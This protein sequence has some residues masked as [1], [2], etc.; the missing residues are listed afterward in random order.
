MVLRLWQCE[1]TIKSVWLRRQV[2]LGHTIIKGLQKKSDAYHH[3]H[4]VIAGLA[5]STADALTLL[6]N[7][8]QT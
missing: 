3:G 1:K 6:E 7:G 4:E 5:G 2:S 8:G